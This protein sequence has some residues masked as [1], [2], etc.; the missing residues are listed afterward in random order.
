MLEP[1]NDVLLA[2]GR[3]DAM[4][5]EFAGYFDSGSVSEASRLLVQGNRPDPARVPYL[6]D[7]DRVVQFEF[8][9]R[10]DQAKQPA[11]LRLHTADQSNQAGAVVEATVNGRL[12][13]HSLPKGLGV[14]NTQAAH[15]AFP[16]TLAFQ[17]P[18]DVLRAGH[19]YRA[20]P[21][22]KGWLV[23]L[24]RDGSNGER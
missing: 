20:S 6:L 16:A 10:E 22:Q 18:K 8:Q 5:C 9:L 12:F 1:S 2:L 17:L 14:Q 23:H 11:L 13:A 24:G 7:G 3:R 4:C 19:E 15:L 21:R